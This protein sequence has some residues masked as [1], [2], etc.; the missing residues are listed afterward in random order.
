MSTHATIV[1]LGAVRR[2]PAWRQWQ[3]LAAGSPQFLT[4]E[5]FT[6]AARFEERPAIVVLAWSEAQLVGALPLVRE[7]GRLTS[8]RCDYSPG[9]D[10]RGTPAGVDAIWQALR[11]D[12]TWTDVVLDKIPAD[13][14][15]AA[16]LAGLA[17]AAGC[18][19]SVHLDSRH[20]QFALHEFEAA[21]PPKFRTN[22]R[23]CARK[24]GSVE[25]ER[26]AN[27]DRAALDEALAIEAKAWKGS[28]GT[29]I[30]HD[31]CAVHFY[32]VLAR[33][34]GRR[35]CAAL[36]FLRV[37]G[38]RV[39]T[40]FA[41]EDGRTLY[42][43]KIGYNP[44]VANLSPGHLLVWRVA[45]E[46]AARGLETFDFVGHDDEWKR[47]WTSD[48][49]EH[50]S[51]TIYRDSVSGLSRFALRHVVRPH[52]P[53]Q[54]AH[55]FAALRTGCQRDDI[56]GA[57]A[58]IERV[59]G[60]LDRGLGIKTGILRAIRPTPAR[61]LMGEPSQFMP[62]DWVRVK[63]TPELQAT[64]DAR[65]RTRGLLFAPTQ[66][67]TVDGVFQVEKQVRRLRDDHGC[68]RPISRTVLLAGVDCAG[69]GSE[70]AGC[71]RHCPMMYRDEWLEPA[72]APARGAS[73]PSITHHA[74]VRSLDEIR[75]GLDPLGR[76]HGVTFLAEME[77]YAGKRFPI[78][79]RI[80]TVFEYD[81]WVPTRAPLYILGGLHCEG[82]ALGKQGPCDR[83][84][85]LTWVED[86]LILEA[87]T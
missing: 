44:S 78:A 33:L 64:L 45:E 53:S 67:A 83:A 87:V 16:H 55:P 28:A 13:S 10:Y 49:V 2:D 30:E 1:D 22:L 31:P 85:A 29:S 18:P 74:R 8:L 35:G 11:A 57:H 43:L 75:A 47:K 25:L 12:R 9:F 37:R 21:L 58:L 50:I 40:L 41:V 34:F 60:R 56:I 24:A 4:P 82:S 46:A 73:R 39:A 19:T 32:R 68:F 72:T 70:P 52:V 6:L 77:R 7:Q 14:L 80:T 76:R 27:P 62:G 5:F 79:N 48:A 71:G 84:C 20:P 69:H 51:L 59:R 26:I 3:A 54:L 17:N 15:L 23:R 61:D 36:Y 66:R 42:A 63:S 86:W 81:R 65:D 38:R